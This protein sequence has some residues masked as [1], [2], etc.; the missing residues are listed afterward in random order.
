MVNRI[1]TYEQLLK[2]KQR[3]QTLIKAQRELVRYDLQEIK[4]ELHPVGVAFSFLKDIT[5]RS[6][7]NKVLNYGVDVVVDLLFKKVL[8]ARTGWLTR[9]TLPFF[10]KNYSSNILSD[11][12]K[13]LFEKLRSWIGNK[14]GKEDKASEELKQY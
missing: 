13:T 14:N 2:E 8:L 6:G 10:V 12:K 11:H 9:L 4:H 5:S 1:Q 3:L 7:K